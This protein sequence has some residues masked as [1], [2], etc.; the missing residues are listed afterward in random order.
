MPSEASLDRLGYRLENWR[1][2][3]ID[4][5][6]RNRLLNYRRTK[7]STVEVVDE[8][9]QQVL[10]QLFN[11]ERFKFDPKPEPEDRGLF[12]EKGKGGDRT[13]TQPS[14]FRTGRAVEYSDTKDLPERHRDDRLQTMLSEAQLG[15]N[16]LNIYRR[17][18]ESMEEQGVNTLFLALGMLEWYDADH[19]DKCSRAPLVMVPVKL[20][21]HSA[22]SA[23]V[24]SSADEDPILNPA[25]VEKL[26]L[27]FGVEL[28]EVPETMEELDLDLLF[29]KIED[30]TTGFP[31]WRLT[32]DVVLGLFSFQKFIMYRDLDRYE[33]RLRA[34]HVV[35]AMCRD[36]EGQTGPTGLPPEIKDASLDEKMSPWS[37]VQ[38]LDADSSQQRAMLAVREGGDL[39]IEG[40]PGTGKSQTITNVIADALHEGKTVL[41]VSEKMAALEVVKTRLESNAE[42]GDH[43]LELHSNKTA[44]TNFVRELSRALDGQQS[45]EGE[46]GPELSRLRTLT[47][48][49]RQY[50]V[51]L[52][53]PQPPLGRSPYEAIGELSQV[54]DVPFVSAPLPNLEQ[55]DESMLEQAEQTLIELAR[56]LQDVGDPGSHPLRGLGLENASRS[57]GR[58]LQ[59]AVA[60]ATQGLKDVTEMADAVAA[61][62]G[63][64]VPRTFGDAQVLVE[65]ARV[66]AD[67]P[68][69]E[70]SVLE[71]DRW[72]E[73]SSEASRLLETGRR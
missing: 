29:K 10:S 67:S 69:A 63:L 53:R 33:E 39:V 59:A 23:F 55:I 16:L 35:Q 15:K 66:V 28:P 5:T 73:M 31:R 19:S 49:L 14:R 62:L 68:G 38:V 13:P 21:R 4:L 65:G 36:E 22:A 70:T 42:L 43:V 26:R 7:V 44:K 64:R 32:S 25:L 34:H 72:N 37:S 57:D 9:P 71:S 2:N 50:V 45:T 20:S 18:K 30:A 54:E 46:D 41:F 58:A 12:T 24:L 51:E 48:E 56:T 61:E 1:R 47:E 27:D 6:R 11:G 60:K 52:H 8:V 17:A 3:L 40:P